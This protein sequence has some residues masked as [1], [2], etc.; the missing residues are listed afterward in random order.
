MLFLQLSIGALNDVAD[1]GWDAGRKPGKP[2]AEGRVSRRTG[3]AVWGTGLVG[4]L[5]LSAPSGPATLAVAVAGATCGYV[6]DLGLSR[7]VLSWLPLAVGLPLLPIHALLGAT[8]Q[9]SAGAPALLPIGVLAGVGLALANGMVDA[10]RDAAAGASTVV[11]VVGRSRAWWMHLVVLAGAIALAWALLPVTT[12]PLVPL[13]IGV[14]AAFVAFGAALSRSER[15][16][17]RER[18]WEAEAVGV[19]FLGAAWVAALVQR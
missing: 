16:G 6:Y 19:A 1:A 17:L 9:L 3:L 10:E 11:V 4:G 14:G 5:A 18:G 8:G 2:I 13:G 7:T 15:V 12:S